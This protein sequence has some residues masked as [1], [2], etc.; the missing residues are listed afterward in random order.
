VSNKDNDKLE[1]R[2]YTIAEFADMWGTSKSTIHRLIHAGDLH[3]FKLGARV[4]ISAKEEK[5]F[6]KRK[7]EESKRNAIPG[8]EWATATDEEQDEEQDETQNNVVQM[9][10]EF[11]SDSELEKP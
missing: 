2:A 4:M 8:Y 5:A 9:R 1:R 3:A 11:P 7:E 6:Q 10:D